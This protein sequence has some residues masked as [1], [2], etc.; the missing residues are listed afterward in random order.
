MFLKIEYFG[1]TKDEYKDMGKIFLKLLYKF[2]PTTWKDTFQ[3]SPL[4]LDPTA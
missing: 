3:E 1:K 2:T 4:Q